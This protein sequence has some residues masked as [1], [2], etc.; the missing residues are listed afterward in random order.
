MTEQYEAATQATGRYVSIK[1][2]PDRVPDFD[3]VKRQHFWAIF[4]GYAIDIR[5]IEEGKEGILDH[6]NMVQVS[7]PGCY[8]CERPYSK[9]LASQKCMGNP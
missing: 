8:H 5:N 2:S 9:F 7:P 6:E 4:V 1:K 3:P